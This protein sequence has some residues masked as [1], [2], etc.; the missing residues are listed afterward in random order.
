MSE[1]VLELQGIAGETPLGGQTPAKPI[2]LTLKAGEI[3]VL[4]GGKETSSLFRLLLGLGK[5]DQGEM[6]FQGQPVLKSGA[7]WTNLRKTIGFGFRDKGLLSNLSLL[8]N[9]DLPAKYHGFYSKGQIKPGQL[10]KD[11][12]Q[13]LGVDEVY[14]PLRPSR[15]GGEL[16][17]QVLLARAIVLNP[18]LLLLDDPAALVPTPFLPSL[19]S[20]ILRRSRLGTAILVGTN[21]Y[22]FG[23]ALAKWVLH[24]EEGTMVHDFTQIVDEAWTQSAKLLL[25]KLETAC[26]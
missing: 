12:L 17:K 2:S 11:A 26:S 4:L 16:R 23:L 6:Y 3:G 15:I 19:M 5:V 10:A 20:W 21:D 1:Y 25:K 24:P 9:V 13:E 22:P 14:W 18:P 7:N 8:D